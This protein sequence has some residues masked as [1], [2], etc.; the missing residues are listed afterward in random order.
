MVAV[1]GSPSDPFLEL[2]PTIVVVRAEEGI[3]VASPSDPFLQQSVSQIFLST[4]NFTFSYT[5]PVLQIRT[6][7]D[8]NFSIPDPRSKKHRIPDPQQRIKV[9]LTQKIVTKL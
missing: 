4:V 6:I 2:L 1:V 3:V 5:T 8:H 9:F 7:Q